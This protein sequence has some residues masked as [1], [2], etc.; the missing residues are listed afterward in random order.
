MIPFHFAWRLWLIY[1]YGPGWI[2]FMSY[3]CITFN[4]AYFIYVFSS[5]SLAICFPRKNGQNKQ[6]NYFKN[7]VVS[8]VI[9]TDVLVCLLYWGFVFQ[10]VVVFELDPLSHILTS[11]LGHIFN[12]VI[13]LAD[14]YFDSLVLGHQPLKHHM[15]LYPI[16]VW[17]VYEA[18][19]IYQA[20]SPD[21]YMKRIPYAA[22]ESFARIR[23][24]FTLRREGLYLDKS[25]LVL[26]IMN[27]ATIFSFYLSFYM[28]Q[29]ME[30]L[31]K[32]SST[33][34][35]PAKN[36]MKINEKVVG[37]RDLEE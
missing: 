33:L 29:W 25:I 24:K 22:I 28:I 20:L 32:Q 13:P 35:V 16:L 4:L 18:R 26:F 31:S 36:R 9:T 14:I 19:M 8:I 27:L 37:I 2:D 3:L 7:V 5:Q 21:Y 15:V 10:D 6:T 1:M 11:M 30:P 12:I 17:G 23:N 34:K